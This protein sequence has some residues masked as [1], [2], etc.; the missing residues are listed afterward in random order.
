[1]TQYVLV[2]LIVAAAAAHMAL[3]LMP[4]AWRG[5]LAGRLGRLGRSGPRWARGG[6]ARMAAVIAGT[7][8]CDGCGGGDRS[9]VLRRWARERRQDPPKGRSPMSRF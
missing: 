7:G 3:V 8:G 1:M 9:G 6:L 4:G 5:T 2:G